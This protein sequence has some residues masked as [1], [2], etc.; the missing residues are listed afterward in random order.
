MPTPPN[1]HIRETGDDVPSRRFLQHDEVGPAMTRRR[2]VWGLGIGLA[3]LAGGH[4]LLWR[5][6][7][8]QME[9]A[10][11]V[12]F[13]QWRAQGWTVRAGTPQRTG[14]PLNVRLEVPDLALS[15]RFGPPGG[16]AWQAEAVALDVGLLHP[17]TLVIDI[18]G[19]QHL[20]IGPGPEIPLTAQS[21]RAMVAL[22]PGV[23]PHDLEVA[24]VGLRAGPP[25][26][27]LTAAR[28]TL[29]LAE[30]L[31]A[32][33]GEAAISVAL[34]AEELTLPPAP[35]GSAWALG[36]RVAAVTLDGA[37]TG[38]LSTLPDPQAR[39]EAW[40]DAGGT[41]ALR[42]IALRWGALNLHGSAT[43]A[44]DGELQPMGTAN[45]RATGQGETLDALAAGHVVAPRVA[46]AAKAV[47]ALMAR[48]PPDGGPA[49]VEL[50]LALQDSTLSM[51]RIPLVHLPHLRWPQLIWS[52]AP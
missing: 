32:A 9:R 33:S 37:V 39:A 3:L 11:A 8:Q 40:R 49:S 10:M 50:P 24:L 4:T 12:Q 31:G 51:G 34:R 22:V 15:G 35:G 48:T 43:L 26:A 23:P 38:P 47:L 44:L 21:A 45:I 13:A 1:H 20:R 46:Q 41:L 36:D 5:W 30:Q 16:I 28:A 29:R 52:D 42:K 25:G 17:R 19:Q 18:L 14:W 7:E 6:G 27:E 2:I